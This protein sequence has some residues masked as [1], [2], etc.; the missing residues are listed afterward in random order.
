MVRCGRGKSKA[1]GNRA[2]P[3]SAV[4]RFCDRWSAGKQLIACELRWDMPARCATARRQVEGHS[5]FRDCSTAADN[6]RPSPHQGG[7]LLP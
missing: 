6:T 7:E 1:F 5:L 2:T 3:L 4:Y